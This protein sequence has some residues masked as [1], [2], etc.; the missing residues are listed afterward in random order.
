[1]ALKALDFLTK[2]ENDTNAL[3]AL[4]IDRILIEMTFTGHNIFFAVSK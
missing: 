1:M 2:A 4:E 3:R